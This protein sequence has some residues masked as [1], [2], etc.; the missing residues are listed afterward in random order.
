MVKSGLGT[1][2]PPPPQPRRQGRGWLWHWS[3]WVSLSHQPPPAPPAPRSAPN[4]PVPPCTPIPC[5]WYPEAARA[6]WWSR[7]ILV[8]RPGANQSI[9]PAGDLREVSSTCTY[10]GAVEH[11]RDVHPR[12]L[13]CHA[14]CP[15]PSH[16]CA[17]GTRAARGRAA[18]NAFWSLHW[19]AP[20]QIWG[21]HELW[22]LPPAGAVY[23]ST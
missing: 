17:G 1:R 16:P 23:S 19:G 3:G 4:P 15:D 2:R 18:G 9:K 13:P 11:P 10:T 21:H 20:V 12:H 5:S 22:D 7:W 14:G 8:Q 6:P